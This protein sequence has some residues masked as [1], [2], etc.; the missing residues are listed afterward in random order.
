MPVSQREFGLNLQH[1]LVVQTTSQFAFVLQSLAGDLNTFHFAIKLKRQDGDCRQKFFNYS[2]VTKNLIKLKK[3]GFCLEKPFSS[4][5]QIFRENFMQNKSE[6]FPFKA[7]Q[8]KLA[9]R[10]TEVRP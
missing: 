8:F 5:I 3:N 6:L 10:A 4:G 9:L 2:E 7:K 1:S